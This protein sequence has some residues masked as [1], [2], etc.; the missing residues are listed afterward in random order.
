[1]A[2][3]R[4]FNTVGEQL[5]EWE[6]AGDTV[7]L[8]FPVI[9]RTKGTGVEFISS[10]FISALLQVSEINRLRYQW[11]VVRY[12]WHVVLRCYGLLNNIPTQRAR[13]AEDDDL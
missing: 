6:A 3:P 10:S 1:M 4:T 8:G 13:C 11:H 9:P 7:A 2:F 12:Q 5:Q